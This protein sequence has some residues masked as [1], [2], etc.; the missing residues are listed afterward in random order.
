MRLNPHDGSMRQVDASL[1]H[2]RFQISVAQ[3]IRNIPPYIQKDDLSIKMT[4]L[5][6]SLR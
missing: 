1:G 6:W 5:E 2:H 4:A 3:F